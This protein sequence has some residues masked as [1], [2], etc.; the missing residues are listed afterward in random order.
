MTNALY[1][2][3][4]ANVRMH[5]HLEHNTTQHDKKCRH[6]LCR[7]CTRCNKHSNIQRQK[8]HIVTYTTNIVHTNHFFF[9]ILVNTLKILRQIKHCTYIL[10]QFYFIIFTIFFGQVAKAFC[11]TIKFKFKHNHSLPQ[12]KQIDYK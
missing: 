11:L 1:N 7:L 12:V 4:I 5:T 3:R 9:S 8:L 6:A 2:T 10:L